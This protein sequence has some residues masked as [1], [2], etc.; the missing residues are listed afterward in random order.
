MVRA[1]PARERLRALL[2]G[3]GLVVVTR[4]AL[5][6]AA[7]HVL[8]WPLLKIAGA[9]LLLWVAVGLLANAGDTQAVQP[10]CR[11][12]RAVRA[13]V[14]ADAVMSIDNIL[15]VAAA[16]SGQWLAIAASLAVSILAVVFLRTCC[17][18]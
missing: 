1:L 3:A 12:W 9:V 14:F 6:L 13:I 16:A 2:M 8:Q 4:I 7:A 11:C 15:S 10:A 5:T 18:A 17:L